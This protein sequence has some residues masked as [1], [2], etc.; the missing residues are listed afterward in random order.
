MHALD[1]AQAFALALDAP[2]DAIHNRAFNVGSEQNNV[3]VA[4]I[5]QDV[6]EAVPGSRL[7]ITGEN[8]NDPRSYRV[9]FSRVR[10]ALPGFKARWTVMAG[11]VELV[12]AYQRHQ[13]DKHA[14]DRRF[15][16]LARLADRQGAGTVDETLRP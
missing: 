4:D 8:G 15:T 13:L 5:A 2:R 9:D 1:I 3:T 7:V 10:Q 6:I 11:A 12:E 16:R 14:F